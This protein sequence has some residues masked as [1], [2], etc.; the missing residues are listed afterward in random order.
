MVYS[1]TNYQEARMN[2][3][4]AVS[5]YVGINILILLFL[6]W[7][8]IGVRRSDKISLGDGGDAKLAQ[9]I[10]AHGNAAEY[11]PMAM[12]GLL[13]MASTGQPLWAVHFGGIL[14]TVGRALH[15][16]GLTNKS[17]ISFGRFYGMVATLVSLAWIAVFCLLGTFS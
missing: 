14:F 2:I 11:M 17:G 7:S 5:P 4:S 9:K 13:V 1:I 16:Y 3:L 15:A 8:V 12:I 10:R 6:S